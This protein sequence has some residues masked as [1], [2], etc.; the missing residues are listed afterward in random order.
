MNSKK[1]NKLFVIIILI[2]AVAGFFA[3]KQFY[4]TEDKNAYQALLIYPE[5]KTFS[6]FQLTDQ[7]S[8]TLTI[9]DFS[10]KWTLLFFGFTHCPD[11]C[12]TTLAELQTTFKL[13]ETEN[14]SQMPEVLFVSVDPER[15]NPQTL[16]NYISFF[17]PAFN[18]A[19]ADGANILS[20]TSQ[21]G[22]A[23]HIGDH[24]AGDIN[25]SVD[26]TA[27]IFLV[28]PQKQLYGL[29]QSPHDAKKM[30]HDLSLLIG[31]KQ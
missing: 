30:A 23:Y 6:G 9:D 10:D 15:D 20:I 26:H 22:V 3:S 24:Q 11:V 27:A 16:Q 17:N 13:L 28:S 19:T 14:L 25:Y 21:V 1:T 31:H 29:F 2:A 5:K 4:N 7:N 18:A 8:T 12:P